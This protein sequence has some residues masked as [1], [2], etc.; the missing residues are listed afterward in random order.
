MYKVL[1]IQD[2]RHNKE[3][4]GTPMDRGHHDLHWPVLKPLV[5]SLAT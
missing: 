2:G 3:P 5:F 4:T 1:G